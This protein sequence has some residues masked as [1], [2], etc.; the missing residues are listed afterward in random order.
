MKL[1]EIYKGASRL[2]KI[3][4]IAL[5]MTIIGLLDL[6]ICYKFADFITLISRKYHDTNPLLLIFTTTGGVSFLT[7]FVF[8]LVIFILGIIRANKKNTSIKTDHKGVHY[9]SQSTFGNAMWM[10]EDEAEDIFEICNIK[11]MPS[12]VYGQ[13]TENGEK[14]VGY[15]KPEGVELNRNTLCIAS[16]GSGKSHC[17]V[18]P[19][20]LQHIKAG[21]SVCASDPGGG[22]YADLS[23]YCKK[24]GVDTKVIN[25][26]DPMYSETWDIIKECLNPHTERLDPLRLNQFVDTFMI[27]TGDGKRDFF[28]DASSNLIRTVIAYCCYTNESVMIEE[29]EKLYHRISKNG[30]VDYNDVMIRKLAETSVSFKE[31][32]SKIMDTALNNGYEKGEIENLFKMIK[33]YAD[34]KEP[35]TFD[36]VY[37]LINNFKDDVAEVLQSDLKK[38]PEKRTIPFWHPCV[39]SFKIFTS[40]STESVQSSAIQGAQL[41]F[42]VFDDP[43]LRHVVSTPGLNLNEFN[44]KQTALFIIVNDKSNETKPIA[45]LLFS[46]LFKD[47][48]DIFD[49]NEQMATKDKPNPCL[50]TAVL[51]DDFFSLGIIG[52]SPEVFATI[53]SNARKRCIYI[54]II[55]QNYGQLSALYGENMK[56]SIQGNCATLL[57]LRGNDPSTTQFISGF[58]GESTILD[59]SHQESNQFVMLGMF[60]PTFRAKASQRNIITPGEARM[61]KKMLVIRQSEQPLELNTLPWTELPQYKECTKVNIYEQIKPYDYIEED[62][63][64]KKEIETAKASNAVVYN[65][66]ESLENLIR[67]SKNALRQNGEET[68]QLNCDISD[69]LGMVKADEDK[70]LN[71]PIVVK[72]DETYIDFDDLGDI[73]A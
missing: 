9:M 24:H 15:K 59:E 35:F 71:E 19:F 12:V 67:Y 21:D 11:D 58:A 46:F 47:T 38:I 4:L 41:R 14:A 63:K 42:A 23:A 26:Q 66:V 36:R 1:I 22:L 68:Q 49:R 6:L 5:L 27:N 73:G 39:T 65:S 8:L 17:V 25:L 48:Q 43:S 69:E 10:E 62:A 28:Y 64:H 44:L 20:F 56:N 45:S 32:R 40:N 37:R 55:L 50:G 34:L 57:Y 7:I 61:W 31:V 54:L 3:G 53:M 29:Y 51:L 30:F 13:L 60:Q 52:N 2:K 72:E 33:D 16:S 70:K 18:K